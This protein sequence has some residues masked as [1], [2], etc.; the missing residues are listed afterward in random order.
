MGN[1]GGSNTIALGRPSKAQYDALCSAGGV[2]VPQNCST[3]SPCGSFFQP[4]GRNLSPRKNREKVR[5]DIKDFVLS[6]LGA[7]NVKIELN[8]QNLDV[9]IDYILKIIEDYAPRDYFDYYTFATVP[10]KSVYKM[11]DDIG[12]VRNVFYKQQ[13]NFSFQAND[14]DGAI[15]VEYFYPGGAYA[16]IQGGLI[17]PIQPIW[18]RAG[19]WMLYK[20][21]E[22][23]FSSMSSNIGGWEWVSDMGYIKLYPTPCN[24]TRVIVHY[25]Q[26]C[27]DWR[28]MT[29]AMAEGVLWH[30]MITL[31]HIRGKYTNIPG[32][33]GGMQLDGDYMKQ[34]GWELRDKWLQDL[35]D[36]WGDLGPGITMA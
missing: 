6:T 15:P 2:A 8:S 24:C 5:E 27:K 32:P 28:E 25:L 19:E 14:L 23:M 4:H 16:S 18:G 10:G 17:D 36:R 21:Y 31:G 30:S 1:C 34:K 26:K 13:A 20:Q 7:P 35:L 3:N 29:H 11:P 9:S 33:S 22:Q 12:V